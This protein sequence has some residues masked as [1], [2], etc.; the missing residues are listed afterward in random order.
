MSDKKPVLLIDLS[1][2]FY[3]RWHSK[4][5]S[6]LSVT[7]QTI[8]TV[9]KCVDGNWDRHIAICCDSGRSFRKDIS[10]DYKKSRPEKDATLIET[11]RLTEEALAKQ[12]FLLWKAPGF[13][14]DDIIA[15]ACEAATAAGHE[16]TIASADKDL[17]QL[18]S[19][20]VKT[21]SPATWI[22]RGRDEVHAAFGVWP[23]QIGDWL[24]L[25][26]DKSDDIKG[27]PGVGAKTAAQLLDEYNSVSN[28]YAV[29][30]L[31]PSLV[32]PNKGQKPGEISKAAQSLVAAK[33]N[34][35]LAKRLV[36][37]RFDVPI[38]FEEIYQER[39]PKLEDD[40]SDAATSDGKGPA[41]S[42]DNGVVIGEV[43]AAPIQRDSAPTETKELTV[44]PSEFDKHLEP[45]SASSA[46]Q[47]SEWVT[48]SRLY[49]KL[50]NKEAVFAIIVR[51]RELGLGAMVS[52]DVFSVVEGRV[53][54][55][56]HFIISKAKAHP[57]CEYLQC[58]E[59]TPT[60]ATWE[61]K[62]RKNPKPTRLTYTIEQ[63]KVAGRVKEK[64]QWER[65]PAEMCRK[66]CGVQL[67]RM[68]Y[69]EAALGLY[70]DDELDEE[71][72][73]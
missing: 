62:N 11:L 6:L 31:N 67:A 37:L 27:A 59:T 1:S 30:A 66:I 64:G 39:K 44:R 72:A 52:L 47:F 7:Q 36:A 21:L 5:E 69:P 20:K 25:V 26:G 63:A 2:V 55:S 33:D 48:K 54:P 3:P 12:G 9:D 43:V 19:D 57:D 50:P 68:E 58:I 15:T 46:M 56:A 65:M 8:A 40:F 22:T 49:N 10:P 24:S 17:C 42:N 28:L 16:V 34:V 4:G 35:M 13:E 18:V 60:S 45:Y 38:N 32:L 53:S 41:P 61:T 70:A 14:A 23:H 73:S 51:G 71:M 29:L